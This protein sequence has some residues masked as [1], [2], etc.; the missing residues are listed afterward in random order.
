MRMT[1]LLNV[2]VH[3]AFWLLAEMGYIAFKPALPEVASHTYQIQLKGVKQ[4][5]D[6]SEK[7]YLKQIR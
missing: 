6:P 1:L 4:E 7:W 2:L 3:L 5:P